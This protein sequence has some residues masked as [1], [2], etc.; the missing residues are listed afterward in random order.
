[1]LLLSFWDHALFLKSKEEFANKGRKSYKM[2]G[3][4]SI[5]GILQYELHQSLWLN[6]AFAGYCLSSW[7]SLSL[8]W[9]C[10]LSRLAIIV[11]DECGHAAAKVA[12]IRRKQEGCVENPRH[13]PLH[14]QLSQGS[15]TIP[16]WVWILIL[17]MNEGDKAITST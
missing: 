3:T 10:L 5:L 12:I 17:D 4:S 7:V 9:A 8:P 2:M 1:M 11:A 14:L 6:T 16:N 13:Y 15:V